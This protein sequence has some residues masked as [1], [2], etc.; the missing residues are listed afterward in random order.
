MSER[1]VFNP[2]L[3]IG[4]IA[5]ALVSFAAFVLLLAWGG[6]GGVR[7]SGRA[8]AI[9]ASGIGYRALYE[10][11]SEYHDTALVRD[12][13]LLDTT[14]LLVVALEPNTRPAEVQSLLQRRADATTVLI[15]P[16]WLTEPHPDRSAWVRGVAP[17][18]ARTADRLIGGEYQVEPLS[19]RTRPGQQ[20]L[21]QDELAGVRMRL[22]TSAQVIHGADLYDLVGISGEGALVARLG[23]APHY[24]IADPDLVNNHGL[25]DVRQAEAAVRMLAQLRPGPDG[26]IH[27]DLTMNGVG[28][29][30][31]LLKAMFDP[32]FLALTLALVAAA[33]LA[34]LHGAVRFGPARRPVRAIPFGK[35]ALVENSAGLVRLAGREVRLGAGY[36]DLI[37]DDAARSSAAPAHLHGEALEQWLDR[38]GKAGEAPFAARA[39]ALRSARDRTELVAAARAL[40]HW[41]RDM[42]R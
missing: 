16:K 34:G 19:A 18:L 8:T 24:V 6:D 32:P 42:I 13:A 26:I 29:G 30:N 35:T 27:F 23:E 20:R 4:I 40:F 22:P 21:G 28:D 2:A 1:Q 7:S 11:T 9:S 41:K 33:F 10:L 31:S 38:L 36:A 12:K 25:A 15:L 39:A 14:D 37:R 5:A 17:G 3:M